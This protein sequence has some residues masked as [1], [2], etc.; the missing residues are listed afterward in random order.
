MT[1]T[2]RT[3]VCCARPMRAIPVDGL[4]EGL[5]RWACDSCR[6]RRWYLDDEVISDQAA[7]DLVVG[8]PLPDAAEPQPQ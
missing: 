5:I 6:A 2:V 4:P 3:P 7:L 8:T 1:L